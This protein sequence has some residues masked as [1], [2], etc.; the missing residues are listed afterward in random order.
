MVKLVLA[1][2][3]WRCHLEA[4]RGKGVWWLADSTALSYLI[5]GGGGG[6]G[7]SERHRAR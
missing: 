1:S 7:I 3:I 2:S 6:V 4:A 5:Q